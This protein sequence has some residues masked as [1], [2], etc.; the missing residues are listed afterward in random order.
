MRRTLIALAAILA[1]AGCSSAG[2]TIPHHKAASGT[3]SP[4]VQKSIKD[5]EKAGQAAGLP[6]ASAAEVNAN[7]GAL[8]LQDM[9][10]TDNAKAWMTGCM[11]TGLIDAHSGG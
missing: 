9:P 7:C 3:N 11:L 1:L 4:L 6:G 8:R 5:G 2:S 10:V